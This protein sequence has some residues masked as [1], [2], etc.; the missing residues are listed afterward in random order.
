MLKIV[1]VSVGNAF[2]L[3]PEHPVWTHPARNESRGRDS[4]RPATSWDVDAVRSPAPSPSG[5]RAG[6]LKAGDLICFPIAADAATTPSSP[7]TCSASSGYYLAEGSAFSNGVSNG[8]PTVAL[9]FHIDETDMIDD[10]R[11]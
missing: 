2:E 3:T 11:R 8:V 4:S 10:A 5:S 6:E 1:P 9:S 7:T